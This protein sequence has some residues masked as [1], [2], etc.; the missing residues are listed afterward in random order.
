MFKG[1]KIHV[2][3]YAINQILLFATFLVGRGVRFGACCPWG[4]TDHCLTSCSDTKL[5][6]KGGTEIGTRSKRPRKVNKTSQR[7]AWRFHLFRSLRI[8]I[9]FVDIRMNYISDGL[10]SWRGGRGYK[11]HFHAK[12]SICQ[13]KWLNWDFR[14]LHLAATESPMSFSDKLR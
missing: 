6:G 10:F 4:C 2:Q 9:A 7:S 13:R 1:R 3:K 5:V 12:I 11:S 14:R 8:W